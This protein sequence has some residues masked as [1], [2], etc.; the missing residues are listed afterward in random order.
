[1]DSHFDVVVFGTGLT[2]SIAAASLSKAGYKVVHIDTNPYY[3]GNEASLTPDELTQWCSRIP[4]SKPNCCDYACKSQTGTVQSSRQYS[5]SLSPS[6]IPSSGSLIT[7][8]IA[9]GVARYGGFR[10]LD[11][12]AVYSSGELK[13]IPGSKEAIFKSKDISLV[14]KRRLMRFLLFA[15]GDFESAK[16]LEGRSEMPFIEFLEEVF[17]LNQDLA[18]TVANALALCTSPKEHTILALQR[19]RQYL[20]SSGK[21]GPSPFLIG[22]YGGLGELAQGYCRTCAVSGGTYILGRRVLSIHDMASPTNECADT[23]TPRFKISVDDVS[24]PIFADLIISSDD[25]LPQELLPVDVLGSAPSSSVETSAF[26]IAIVDQPLAFSKL[27][28]QVPLPEVDADSAHSTTQQSPANDD[29]STALIIFPPEARR[30]TNGVVTVLIE[31]EE[32]FSCPR[33]KHILYISTPCLN[34]SSDANESLDPKDILRPYLMD[35]LRLLSNGPIPEPAF[36]AYYLRNLSTS[37]LPLSPKER[38]IISPPLSSHFATKGDEAARNAETI[39][40]EV[41]KRLP[42]GDG[43]ESLWPPLEEDQND[44]D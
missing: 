14:D 21:Y 32:T 30:Q 27:S 19:T 17:F 36:S 3:G 24:E 35:T 8:L 39:F 11:K 20:R 37:N 28:S 41:V 44:E 23:T 15:S 38:V 25:Y 34:L 13:T 29:I 18:G 5:L 16:E 9:S 33:G 2:E 22:H 7:S 43:V 26:C 10:L 42:K 12:A 1:M 31:G 4:P 6:V 40:W